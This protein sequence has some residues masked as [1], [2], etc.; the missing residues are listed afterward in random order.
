[1]WFGPKKVAVDQLIAAEGMIATAEKL[2]PTRRG[3]AVLRSAYLNLTYIGKCSRQLMARPVDLAAHKVFGNG[4]LRT[5]RSL[6]QC[7]KSSVDWRTSDVP[8]I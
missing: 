4:V 7:T 2:T 8:V 3:G 5:F 6:A 1:M